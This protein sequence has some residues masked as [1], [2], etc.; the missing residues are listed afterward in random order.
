[1]LHVLNAREMR[2][3]DENTIQKIGVPQLVL[4]E[5]AALES[6]NIILEKYKEHLSK[7]ASILIIAGNGNNGGDGVALARLFHLMGMDVTILISSF[8]EKYSDA[9]KKQCEIADFYQIK[10]EHDIEKIKDNKYRLIVDALFG[11]GVSRDLSKE[12]Q[13]LLSI[14][15]RMQAIKVALDIP[16]GIC[17]DNGHVFG[18]AFQADLTIT[19]GFLKVG[20]LL[21]PG[22]QYC[23]QVVVADIG[24]DKYSLLNSAPMAFTYE[25]EAVLTDILERRSDNSHKGTYGKVLLLAGSKDAPGA[26]LLA[27]RSIMRA[28]AGMLKLITPSCNKEMLLSNLPEAMFADAENVE[29]SDAVKWCDQIVVGPGLGKGEDA[30]RLFTQLIQELLEINH[31]QKGIQLSKY[32]IIIDADG[33][34]LMAEDEVLY[35]E[36]VRLAENMPVII[37]PHMAELARLMKVS[38]KELA[39]NRLSLLENFSQNTGFITVSKDAV[40][41]VCINKTGFRYYI[42]QTGNNGMATAG[43]GDVLSG[44]LGAVLGCEKEKT[45]ERCFIAA[46]K[47]VYLHGLAGDAAAGK[48]SKASLVASDIIE[49]LP[50]LLK[51]L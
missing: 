26:A 29:I 4:M 17:A 12:H 45:M 25:K 46:T 22:K 9:L 3:A 21:Y 16:S 24:I 7:G 36:V 35:N 6:K 20:L 31:S 8:Q 1:M 28:G 43:S 5:R 40:S 51:G 33:L 19:F 14:V 37:T 10:T 13:N 38:V 32:S 44:I 48:N 50:N 23:G 30:R 34:N 39:E 11:I 41:V 15:N 2:T 42:N 47:G 49:Q 27:G 18:G